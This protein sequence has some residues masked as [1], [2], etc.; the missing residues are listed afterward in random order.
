MPGNTTRENTAAPAYLRIAVPSPL[1]RTFDYLPPADLFNQGAAALADLQPGVRVRVPFGR[2]QVVGVL[3]ETSCDTQLGRDQLRPALEI[4]DSSPVLPPSLVA[5]CQ[6]AAAYYQHPLGEVLHAAM[7][8]PLRRGESAEPARQTVWALSAEARGLPQTAFSRAPK[9]AL[10]FQALLAQPALSRDA[11]RQLGISDTTVKALAG[12]GVISQSSAEITT[13]PATH[14]LRESPLALNPEQRGAIDQ[15]R[16][17]AFNT[18]LL[19]G[20]TGS[21]KTEVY[22]QAIAAVLEQG[23]QALVLVPEIGLTP[24]TIGRFERRFCAPV[25]ALHS[26]LSDGQRLQAWLAA[27]SGQARIVIGTRSAVFTPLP[28][29]GII[30]VDEEHDP[31]FKQQDGFRYSARDLAAVRARRHAIP[32]ILGSATPALETLHNA[33]QGR[34]HHLRLTRRAGGAQAPLVQLLDI[35]R[36]AMEEGFSPTLLQDIETTLARGEQVLV[37]INRRGF[38]PT[39]I[40]HDCGWVANCAHCDARLTVHRHP[41]HLHCHHC[42]YQRPLPQQCPQ[43]FSTNLQQLGQG[44][45]R[46]EQFLQ[47]RFGQVPVHRIDRDSTRRKNALAGL[48]QDVQ[49]GQPCILVGTQML[50]KGHHLP[51]VTL[52]A[53]LEAD[54]GL[55]S[56]DFRGPERMGQLLI[57]VAGRAGRADKPGRVVIQSHHC[58]HPLMQL[59]VSEGYQAF[60]RK[61]L[62]ERQIG[63][64]PPYRYLVLIKAESKRPENALAFLAE[65]RKT[66]QQLQ[67]PSPQL[68]YLGPLPALMEKRNNRFRYQLLINAAGRRARQTLLQ[69]LCRQLEA[70]PLSRRVRWAVDVDPQDMT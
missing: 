26:G 4:L 12:K 17:Q 33:M 22:L 41:P 7:P 49:R 66:A 56:A 35:R 58:Q 69:S 30:I 51:N 15:L 47:Q 20:A 57:Q 18:Y 62:A 1:R 9:Q 13:A 55:L 42:D 54:S 6:W 39:L 3:V 23:R 36:L 37:F 34:F 43:C 63:G 46:S 32:L 25:A 70:H 68:H 19:E 21:G 31:S 61:L 50:A 59:L 44:T 28:E 45:E 38:A 8:A 65:A 2:Q 11:I 52:V 14:T 60:A 29:P 24:Q 48:L 16:Y 40:C 10:L 67:A 64:L 53:I 5:L 27:A